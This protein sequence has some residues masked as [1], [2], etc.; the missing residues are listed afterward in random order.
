M[1]LSLFSSSIKIEILFSS[2]RDGKTNVL[3]QKQYKIDKKR[4][5]SL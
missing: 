3:F 1:I 2:V 4:R 5:M